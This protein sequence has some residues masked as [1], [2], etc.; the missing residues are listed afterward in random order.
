[1][2]GGSAAG[3]A[4]APLAGMSDEAKPS[5]Y[6]SPWKEA[7]EIYFEAFIAFFFP[8]AHADIDWSAGHDFLDKE[9]QQVTREAELGRR[10]VDKL[11]RVHLHGDEQVWVL[12]HVEVQSQ[13]DAEFAERMYIYNYRLFD[14]FRRK[15]A[16]LAVL[17]DHSPSWRPHDFSYT[18][19]GCTASLGF[20]VVKLLD[21]RQRW[22]ELEASRNPFAVV[23]MAQLEALRTRHDGAGRKLAKLSLVRELHRRGF[24]RRDVR[25]LF[26]L[27]DWM[28]SLPEELDEEFWAQ[29]RELD[30][31]KKMPYITSIERIGI[32]K[33][34][35]EG[36]KEGKE[37][38]GLEQARHDVIQALEVRFGTVPE[39][40]AAA[41]GAVSKLDLLGDLLRQAILAES[42]EGFVEL[43]REHAGE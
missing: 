1:M 23:V 26:G 19:W 43:L 34:R 21:Y 38:G 3:L 4:L 20:P 22:A 33:G 14:R 8:E 7:L 42:L 6:D 41:V 16:S 11:A 27:I 35:E 39:E 29:V 15:V 13:R 12:V 37:E 31:E 28:L 9:L 2:F 25:Q 17:A 24:G 30:E 5:D 32:R 10:T 40:V 18:L 36:L